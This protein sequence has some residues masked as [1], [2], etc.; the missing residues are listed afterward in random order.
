VTSP[1]RKRLPRYAALAGTLACACAGAAAAWSL[2]D[3]REQGAIVEMAHRHSVMLVT[4]AFLFPAAVL[5]AV[6][7]VFRRY[8][9]PLQTLID[10]VKLVNLSNPSYRLKTGGNDRINEL[11]QAVNRT[12]DRMQ[13]LQERVDA[14]VD[15]AKRQVEE[16]KG[17]LAALINEFPHGVIVCNSDGAILLVNRTATTMLARGG[18][19]EGMPGHTRETPHLGRSVFG[20]VDRNLV[21]HGL[22]VVS[23]KLARGEDPPGSSFVTAGGSTGLLHVD[24]VPALDGSGSVHGAVLVFR[25]LS[26][27]GGEFTPE[28]AAYAARRVRDEISATDLAQLVAR[29]CEQTLDVHMKAVG[30]ADGAWVRVE[31]LAV[32]LAIQK[33]VDGIKKAMGAVDFTCRVAASGEKVQCDVL[34]A[35]PQL[36]GPIIE[37][38]KA[39]RVFTERDGIVH[40]VGGVLERNSIAVLAARESERSLLRFEVSAVKTSVLRRPPGATMPSRPEFYDFNLFSAPAA[41][42]DTPLPELVYTVFDTETTGLDPSG[43]DEIISIGAVR[44]VGGRVLRQDPFDELVDPLRSVP[45]ASTKVHGIDGAMLRGRPPLGEVLPSFHRFAAGTVLVGH[46]IGF[47]LRFLQLKEESCRVRFENPILDTLLLSTVIHPRMEDHS[48]EAI[49]G[50]LGVDIVGR[51]TALGDA[52]V[53]G[54][55]F[56]KFLPLLADRG[57]LTLRKAIEASRKSYLARVKY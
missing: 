40:T 54:E 19:S 57:I 15:E 29:R 55:L 7:W 42:G 32:V 37:D 47:D 6:A 31:S 11:V 35:G 44:L 4:A 56:L 30:S 20:F 13:S 17:V 41:G 18:E 1:F 14:E 27:P 16:E 9:E 25:E 8:I 36:P 45:E 26:G 12:L 38:C 21:A 34:W 46:N 2:L 39:A 24:L 50:R 28:A 43:G 49:A 33:F 48:I 10:E 51:H 52:I 22:D 53:T 23:G 3:A 5:L